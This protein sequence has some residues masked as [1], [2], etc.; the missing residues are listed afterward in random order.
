MILETICVGAMQANC[1]I[2]AC[3]EGQRA[4]IIDPGAQAHKINNTLK[5][6]GLDPGIVVNT[7]GHYD[8]VGCDDKFGVPVYVH[9]KDRAMLE[10]PQLNL[11]SVFALDFAVKSP[12]RTVKE[13]D[14]I[15]EAG[16][17]FKVIYLPGHTPGGMGLLMEKP[18]AKILFTGDALF[19]GGI[20]RSDLAG[21][22]GELLVRSIKEKLLV[23]DPDTVI[24]PGHG[25]SSTIGHEKEN[26]E[27]LK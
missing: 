20:G 11:S 17:E 2:V 7:H 13:G 1:Y 24:Y 27:F 9:E 16:V 8:H 19:C 10:D 3:A 6:Y 15:E 12:I 21:G 25:L 23:L 4:V 18:E 5:K 14:I 22:D 26:N